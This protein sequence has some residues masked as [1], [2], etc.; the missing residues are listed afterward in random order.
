MIE[1]IVIARKYGFCMGVKRAI[2]I[3][4]KTAIDTDSQVTILNEIVHNEAV[5]ERFRKKGVGQS[6]SV[7]E[8]DGGTL[9]ISAHGVEPGVKQAAIDQGLT[10]VDAT[11]PLVRNIYKII[12]KIIPQ[13]YHLI[14]F[15]DRNHDET[16]GVVGHAPDRI[17]VISSKSELDE[18]PAWTER[19]LGLT[20]QTT[21]RIED[22]KSFEQAA[23]AK[24]PHIETFDTICAA[25][26]QLQSAVHDLAPVVD[27]ILV[28]GSETS[29]NSKRLAR[30]SQSLCGRGELIGSA[31][32]I[33][34]E[35]FLDNH[36]S[37][38][39]VARVGVTAGASTPDFLVEAVIERLM[40]LSGGTASLVR[41]AGSRSKTGL[42]AGE[43]QAG[44]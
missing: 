6:F 19:K 27:M 41:L 39:G 16:K 28:V 26:N 31:V 42:R 8:V 9:I 1:K 14:H 43:S 7:S 10:V 13:G 2:K 36:D 40:K 21:H 25:T 15:G 3:A 5:V 33:R 34:D 30:I 22:F 11:C 35:W 38:G 44:Q 24:W 4:E 23:Q 17:T 20:V 37:N 12:H 32:D 29:A 18:Y